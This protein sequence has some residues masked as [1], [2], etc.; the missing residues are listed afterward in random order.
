MPDRDAGPHTPV[1]H[2]LETAR[3]ALG[4]PVTSLCERAGISRGTWY[5]LLQPGH[6]PVRGPS[7]P[8]PRFMWLD[9][10]KLLRLAGFNTSTTTSRAIPVSKAR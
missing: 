8:W 2:V 9:C 7:S 6:R 4:L 5:G 10:D 3:S 1:A